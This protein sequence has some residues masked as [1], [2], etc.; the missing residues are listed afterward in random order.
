MSIIKSLLPAALLILLFGSPETAAQGQKVYYCCRAVD[1][2][3]IDGVCSPAEWAGAQ[4]T[5]GFVEIAPGAPV[6]L[7][8]TRVKLLWDDDYLYIFAILDD[9]HIWARLSQR[10]T[11]VFYDND[12]EVF[13]DPDGDTHNYLELE[14]NA[15]GTLWDLLLSRPY[16]DL[17]KAI[18][19][20]NLNGMKMAIGIRGT[21]NYPFDSD[22]AWTVEMALPMRS[23]TALSPFPV[24]PYEGEAWRV[25]FSRVQWPTAVKDSSYIKVS[26][27][28][29]T[30][31]H[32]EMNWV[33]SPFESI[34]MHQPEAWGYLVFLYSCKLPEEHWQD[35][36]AG[37]K[38]YL[39]ELY[40]EQV[41]YKKDSGYYA[42]RVE[43]IDPSALYTGI[44]A[45]KPEIIPGSNQYRIN[46]NFPPTGKT[47]HIDE[48]GRIWY[49]FTQTNMAWVHY[50]PEWKSGQWK[51]CFKTVSDAGIKTV[52]INAEGD[53]IAPWVGLASRYGLGVQSWMWMLNCNDSA[54]LKQHPDWYNVNRRGEPSNRKPQYVKYY[55]WL[56]PNN[57]EVAEYLETRINTAAS[58]K[59]LQGLHFDYFRYPDVILPVALQPQYKIR[60]EY[61]YPQYD[62]C[63]CRYCKKAFLDEYGIDIDT[64]AEPPLCEAWREFRQKSL[65]RLITRLQPLVAGKNLKITAAVF[66]S[67]EIARNLV[68]QNWPAWP[69]D[70]FMPMTYPGFYSE[71][72][73]W[74]GKCITEGRREVKDRVPVYAG[75]FIP[76]LK[77]D[78]MVEAIKSAMLNGAS[79][80]VIFDYNSMTDK[81]WEYYKIIIDYLNS[82]Q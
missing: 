50:N 20:Y 71:G 1:T 67:P 42:A 58:V 49:T 15:R 68:R 12:F 16:R 5:D 27:S 62:Y 66:P 73:G 28:A 3:L 23:L 55:K 72:V 69:V 36:D 47:W 37:V 80:V 13:I 34:D 77:P 30:P 33:W 57:P 31:D 25:N 35:P 48:T 9:P 74:I 21:L 11:V 14:V 10:D 2:I 54:I 76:D 24:K 59:G 43:K 53:K 40:F 51:K 75:L 18:T 46:C 4:W 61:E 64:V 60:Q 41:L 39:R 44:G 8:D 78:Q 6:P 26:H 29:D 81:H 65:T 38:S 7:Y 56:C 82:H 52:L 22:T 32:P 45:D 63:Y 70:G 19:S 17:G 79:G